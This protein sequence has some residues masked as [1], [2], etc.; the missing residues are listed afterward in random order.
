MEKHRAE[1]TNRD[2]KNCETLLKSMYS[3]EKKRKV[4]RCIYEA[5]LGDPSKAETIET[6]TDKLKT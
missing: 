5:E 6:Y 3:T 4:I 1:T 2:Y